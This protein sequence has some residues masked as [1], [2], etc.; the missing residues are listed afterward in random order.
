MVIKRNSEKEEKAFKIKWIYESL[1]LS[2][3]GYY[4]RI[5]R[6]KIKEI[7]N[8][9][10]ID[11]VVEIRQRMPGTGTRKLLNHLQEKFALNNIKMG[12]DTLFD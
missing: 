11:L 9:T 6:H 12:R 1:G 2:K 10:V 3:Q 8:N 5:T 7:R 4:Q